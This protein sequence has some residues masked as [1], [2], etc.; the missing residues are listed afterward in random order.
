MENTE[1]NLQQSLS[2]PKTE[3]KKFARFVKNN[4]VL[5]TAIIGLLAIIVVYFWQELQNNKQLRKV[6]K[7]ASEQL[8]QSNN[9]M[10]IVLSKPLIWSIR[11]EMLRGNLE[12]VNIYVKDIVKEKNFQIVQVTDPSGKIILS[13][14]KKLEGKNASLSYDSTLLNANAIK[15]KN[16]GDSL[17]VMSA[18]IMGYDKKLGVLIIEYKTTSFTTKLSGKQHK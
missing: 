14:N 8:V 13:T 16:T 12:Q 10:L 7:M 11:S 1:I 17:L 15:I 3:K 2:S 18:P 5:T 4:P 9:E 6:K